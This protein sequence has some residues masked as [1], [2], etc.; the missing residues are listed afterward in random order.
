MD[1]EQLPK[2]VLDKYTEMTL[3]NLESTKLDFNDYFIYIVSSNKE[4]GFNFPYILVLPKQANEIST[5]VVDNKTPSASTLSYKETIEKELI[6]NTRVSRM[7]EVILEEFNE[8]ILIPII[9]RFKGFYTTALGSNVRNN[10]MMNLKEEIKN[11]NVLM[12]PKDLEK[13]LDIPKQYNNVIMDAKNFLRNHLHLNVNDKVIQIGYSAAS[14]LASNYTELYPQ[15][16]ECLIAGGTTGLGIR[17]LKEYNYPLGIRD[18]SNYDAD[19]SKSVKRFF[20]IGSNDENDPAL[21]NCIF[22]EKRDVNGNLKPK[23]TE[24]GNIIPIL[25]DN[26][27]TAVNKDCYTDEEVDIIHR[28]FGSRINDRFKNYVD[29]LNRFGYNI[30]AK[31]Y[32][33]DHMSVQENKDVYSDITSFLKKNKYNKSNE[34]I[35]LKKRKKELLQE[36]KNRK[37]QEDSLKSTYGSKGFMNIILIS[38]II[39]TISILI[40]FLL[41]I[42]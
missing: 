17:P 31:V 24:D 11:G 39:I 28:K 42:L 1:K 4:K 34:I 3:K 25:K 38:I 19:A 16:V 21:C 22:D 15:N 30:T 7:A 26:K 8:P 20:F 35:A 29:S 12:D 41:K 33:G 2:L 6:D 18:I 14:K 13:L 5:I 27:Y 23:L 9:P 40:L 32:D 37:I 10:N 36:Q